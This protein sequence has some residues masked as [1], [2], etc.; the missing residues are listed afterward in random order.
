MPAERG[1]H[2]RTGA[3]RNRKDGGFWHSCTAEDRSR[4]E[5]AAVCDPLPDERAGNSGGGGASQDRKVH[6]W[7][8]GATRL[9]RTGDRK[10]DQWT[11]G[12][13]DYSRYAGAC[14]GSYAPSHDQA[15]PCKYGS[16]GRGG[17]NAEYGFQ[18]G[19]GADFGTDSERAS[20]SAFLGD[21]A[22]ADP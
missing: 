1:G 9:R 22:A 21:D 4:S 11:P 10:A 13:A 16:A 7:R 8:K 12:R 17:R 5:K 3:D 20:D 15:R 2:D 19:Y 18:G 6:A 14:H